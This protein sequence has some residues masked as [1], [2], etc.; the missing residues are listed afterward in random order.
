MN[1]GLNSDYIYE[2]ENFFISGLLNSRDVKEI[3]GGQNLLIKSHTRDTCSS[4]LNL[5]SRRFINY[6]KK[7][8]IGNIEIKMYKR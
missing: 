1:S 7:I 2:D 5:F 8:G 6:L 4:S 3:I